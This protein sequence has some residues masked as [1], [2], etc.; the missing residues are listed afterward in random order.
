M[1]KTPKKTEA[2]KAPAQRTDASGNQTDQPV[3][4]LAEVNDPAHLTDAKIQE[5][6]GDDGTNEA[7]NTA[8]QDVAEHLED[9]KAEAKGEDTERGYYHGHGGGVG[10]PG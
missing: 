8:N 5:I 1:T 6:S 9:T 7:H 3:T 4:K 10:G 2:T